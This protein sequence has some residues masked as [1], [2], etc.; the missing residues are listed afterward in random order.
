MRHLII[1]S[2]SFLIWNNAASQ[3]PYK[4]DLSASKITINGTSSIHD[5][6]SDLT[7]FSG[8]GVF[9]IEQQ[10][11]VKAD[12]VTISMNVKS[13]KSGKSIMDSKTRDALQ[14]EDFPAITF[15]STEATLISDKKMRCKGGLTMAGITREIVTDVNIEYINSDLIINGIINITMSKY[16]I[17]PPVALLGTLK[18]GDE[19]AVE[20]NLNFKQNNNRATN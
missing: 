16:G 1:I 12:N 15:K 9:I 8:N 19:V 11:L 13:I 4:I 14:E 7:K 18:T 17:E 2:L 20:F 3:A 5:W 6:A 10:K